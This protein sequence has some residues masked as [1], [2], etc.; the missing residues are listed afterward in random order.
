MQREKNGKH[1]IEIGV[2]TLMDKKT[3]ANLLKKI[4]MRGVV[5]RKIVNSLG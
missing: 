1:D 2:V 3:V 5:K 4:K